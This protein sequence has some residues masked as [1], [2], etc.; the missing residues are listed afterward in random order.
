MRTDG[1]LS[2]KSLDSA[3]RESLSTIKEIQAQLHLQNGSCT[4]AAG[5]TS[6]IELC[7]ILL[8]EISGIQA[9]LATGL[10]NTGSRPQAFSRVRLN[11]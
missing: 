3:L 11:A 8:A 2:T 5:L 1:I 4:T 9:N 10:K 7:D 6:Q